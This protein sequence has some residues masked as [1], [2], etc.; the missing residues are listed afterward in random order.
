MC[1][2]QC[3]CG[4]VVSTRE[5]Q[6]RC[7]RCGAVLGP[8]DKLELRLEQTR[9]ECEARRDEE[10]PDR[11]ACDADARGDRRHEA[12][13]AYVT[14]VVLAAARALWERTEAV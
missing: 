4:M 9:D 11:E 8:C 10:A 13:A 5:R 2:L 3:T 6:R 1:V 7:I 14:V 12:L